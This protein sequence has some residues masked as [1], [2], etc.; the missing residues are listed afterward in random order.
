MRK[1][2]SEFKTSFISEA[3]IFTTNKDYF[4]FVEL[5][6]AACWIA[7]DGIDSDDDIKSAEIAVKSIFADFTEKPTISKRKIKKYI[8]NANRILEKESR[9]IRLKSSLII[10]VTDYSKVV[11]AVAGNARLYHFR[12]GRFNFKTKDQSM[13][14]IM[15]DAGKIDEYEIDQHEEKNN[16]INYLGKQNNFK[17]FISGKYKLNDGDVMLLCTAGFWEN[18]NTVEMIQALK[19]TKEPEEFVDNLEEI[20]LSKQKKL[21]NNYTAA[22]IF[23]NRIFKENNKDKIAYVKKAIIIIL[24]IIIIAAGIIAYRINSQKKQTEIRAQLIK[25]E[26]NGDNFVKDGSFD[27]ALKEY[28]DAE[29]S[30]EKLKVKDKQKELDK[31]LQI[32]QLI[33]DGDKKFTD[34]DYEKAEDKYEKAKKIADSEEYYDKKELNAKITKTADFINVLAIEKQGDKQLDNQDFAGA[35]DTYLKAKD[36]A[37]QVSFEEAKK[38]LK[39]KIQEADSKM[40][41]LDKKQKTIQGNDLEKLGDNYYTAQDYGK[42]LQNYESAQSMYQNLNNLQGVLGIAAKIKDVQ[43]KLNPPA[44]NDANK[45]G[46]DSGKDKNSNKDT[47]NNTDANPAAS[48]P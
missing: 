43:E 22:A 4:A 29:A 3:G 40:A 38:E 37:E 14:Q 34:K 17:P 12:K 42:A 25:H 13:A 28:Q 39:S 5:D 20:L 6:D 46:G 8:M 18:V 48:N 36:S 21:L 19:D 41:D 7:A 15:C 11:W 9:S 27:K 30:L 2:N 33:V 1:D 24:P 31:K 23:G 35:K 26:T 45:S 10:V 44:L 16:L 32:T 47:S